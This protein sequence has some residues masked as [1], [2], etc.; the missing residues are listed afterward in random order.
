LTFGAGPKRG[1]ENGC[2]KAGFGAFDREPSQ[3]AEAKPLPRYG[4][5]VYSNLCWEKESGDAAGNR[6]MLIRDG[7]GDRLFF[8]WSDGPLEGPVQATRLTISAKADQIAF[9]VDIGAQ[10]TVDG[11]GV[12][13]GKEKPDMQV[14]HGTI[15]GESL[16]LRGPNVRGDEIL[17]WLH[18]FAA[19]VGE[20][21]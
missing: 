3:S 17:P 12:F 4:M 20:C 18:D 9:S 14:L 1:P 5:F 21:R 8:E 16:A 13:A 11:H 6:I 10:D 15:D 2:P 19:K 7:D